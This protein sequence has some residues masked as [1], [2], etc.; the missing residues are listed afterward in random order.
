MTIVAKKDLMNVLN[1]LSTASLGKGT[2]SGRGYGDITV[3][4]WV[5]EN[6]EPFLE[7]ARGGL[8]I[9]LEAQED[10]LH[11]W[12]AKRVIELKKQVSLMN[13]DQL[14]LSPSSSNGELLVSSE[15]RTIG[16]KAQNSRDYE[17][18]DM[19]PES[20]FIA[21]FRGQELKEMIDRLLGFTSKTE[22]RPVLNGIRMVMEPGAALCQATDSH[23]L[24]S[25]RIGLEK[26]IDG[27]EILLNLYDLK[28]LVS[29]IAKSDPDIFL[30]DVTDGVRSTLA[31]RGY[32]DSFYWT[33][34]ARSIEGNYPDVDRLLPDKEDMLVYAV[35]R[36]ALLEA[37][38]V[39]AASLVVKGQ[40]DSYLVKLQ[41]DEGAVFISGASSRGSFSEKISSGPL[42]G[43]GPIKIGVNCIFLMEALAAYEDLSCK[44]YVP[45]DAENGDYF[46]KP[47]YI[48]EDVL[49]MPMRVSN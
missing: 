28:A 21:A 37:A 40:G 22:K 49:Q 5:D 17:Y 29:L 46:L 13:G 1:M 3:K 25:H 20:E 48:G 43:K 34:Y 4:G 19:G 16:V 31:F 30:Y 27:T 35:E 33:L 2:F 24:I 12:E 45:Q 18:P 42:L 26:G 9:E 7:L 39:A 6:D 36:Q 47:F 41:V 23:R 32:G 15:K 38:T 11:D 44:L 14:I 8:V 10:E